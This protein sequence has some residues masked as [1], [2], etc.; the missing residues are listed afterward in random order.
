M[1]RGRTIDAA[2]RVCRASPRP[3]RRAFTLLEALVAIGMMVMLVGALALF[4][5]DL[6]STRAAAARTAART[7]SADALFG[8]V[9]TALQTAVVAGGRLGAGVQGD[10][11]R[12]RV[13]SS[14]T[15]AGSGTV[16]ALARAAFS[17]LSATQVWETNGT[18]TV[19][20]G[21]TSSALPATVRAFRLRY[22][23]ADGWADSFDSMDTGALPRAVEVALW[24]GRP[25][26]REGGEGTDGGAA[27]SSG[28]AGA[29]DA[30]DAMRA[31]AEAMEDMGPPDRVRTFAV[32]DAAA[33]EAAAAEAGDAAMGGAA[34]VGTRPGAAPA[35]KGGAP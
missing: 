13:L 8:A 5:D 25:A 32:P 26:A 27:G 4:L 19:E 10:A 21:E 33:G 17:P 15:D 7:R 20:R 14:R 28:A 1:S 24:F 34:G 30:A 12:L 6:G 35:K 9:E 23:G 29:A 22:L 2:G 18:V 3:A 31:R 11:T 16:R